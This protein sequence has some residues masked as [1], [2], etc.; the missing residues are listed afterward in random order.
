MRLIWIL[1]YFLSSVSVA[2]TTAIL[3]FSAGGGLDHS[4]RHFQ[5]YMVDRHGVNINFTF[6][7]GANGLIGL[8]NLDTVSDSDNTL[9]L[10]TLASIAEAEAKGLRFHYI[11]ATRQYANVLVSG[12]NSQIFSYSDL[13][14]N[15][16]KGQI[17]TFGQA[18]PAHMIHLQQFFQISKPN[19]TQIIVNYRGA[20]NVVSDL[21]GDHLNFAILPFGAIESAWKSN[22]IKIYA[23]TQELKINVPVI[24][25]INTSGYGVI[26]SV[27]A[28]QTARN[29]WIRYL[30]QY[31]TDSDTLMAFEKDSSRSYNIGPEQMEKIIKQIQHLL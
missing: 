26:M 2:Q 15:L 19:K 14:E 20:A 8:R 11:S 27:R 18:S 31:L 28:S 16:S 30:F 10:V 6:R 21:I 1:F 29:L 12:T 23:S 13:L 25:I 5:K 24:N 22:N 7:T 9:G 17:F 3:N 4:M